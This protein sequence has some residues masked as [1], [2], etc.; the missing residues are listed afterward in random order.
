M[1]WSIQKLENVNELP[2]LN[3]HIC[4]LLGKYDE[5]EKYFLQSTQAVEALYLR[6]DLMQWVQALN[7]AQNL[8]PEEIPFIAKEYAQQLEF[9]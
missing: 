7:L 5:A 1:V 8:K 4:T 6:R 9:T 3:G 2:L